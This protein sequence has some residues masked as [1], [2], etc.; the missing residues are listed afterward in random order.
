MKPVTVHSRTA[1]SGWG[2]LS[3]ALLMLAALL[4]VGQAV[5]QTSPIGFV[6][7]YQPE[8]E[9]VV[10]GQPIRV[11]LGMPLHKGFVI[12]TGRTGRVGIALRDNTLISLGPDTVFSV[13]DFQFD[14]SV[15]D[16]RLWGNISKGT[17]QYVSGLIAKLQPDAVAVKTPGG[18]VGVR[19][20]RFLIKIEEEAP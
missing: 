3:R 12:K 16:M 7:T 14:P 5:A 8:A 17:M 9:V 13:D 6:K 11:A 15:G 19:G 2:W 10:G 18:V 1:G 4:A 20:T